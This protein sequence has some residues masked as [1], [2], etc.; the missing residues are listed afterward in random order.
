M[1]LV[2]N[3]N[4]CMYYGAPITAA[5][6]NNDIIETVELFSKFDVV[7]V[8]PHTTPAVVPPATAP[9][10]T[11]AVLAEVVRGVK[12]INKKAKFFGYTSLGD[13]VD[14]AAW[15]LQVDQWAADLPT[16]QTTVI[17]GIFIDKFGFTDGIGT[18]TRDNQNAALDYV[19]AVVGQTYSVAVS[20]TNPMDALETFDGFAAPKMGQSSGTDYVL[21][22]G[23]YFK[24]E[25]LA[26]PD[27]EVSDHMYGR[28][29]YTFYKV[30]PPAPAANATTM[31]VPK[32]RML[33]AVCKGN[34]N[35]RVIAPADRMNIINL[36]QIYQATGL[37][38]MPYDNG[39]T[40]KA[41][42]ISL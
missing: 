10:Y 19:R 3:L 8:K 6:A 24:R 13:A 34:D 25:D 36:A 39:E 17:N 21:L 7:I 1:D 14:L 9:A 30:A 4:F 15:K 22:D 40:S 16:T 42:N 12:T 32:I 37:G 23:L 41:L 20:A 33:L 27:R 31:P 2:R 11:P 18:A 29:D 5:S 28:L 35:T 26:L 38:V